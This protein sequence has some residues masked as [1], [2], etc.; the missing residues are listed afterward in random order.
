MK[1][2]PRPTKFKVGDILGWE[3]PKKLSTL[4][5]E[6]D[7][8]N[9]RHVKLTPGRKR[10]MHPALYKV[11]TIEQHGNTTVYR[12][13]QWYYAEK[14][15]APPTGDSGFFELSSRMEVGLKK[16]N[17]LELLIKHNIS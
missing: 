12:I 16:A 6:W 10:S 5:E 4:I 14:V 15:W 13:Y 3:D 17:K 9:A 1:L 8:H 2:K 7:D 11:H